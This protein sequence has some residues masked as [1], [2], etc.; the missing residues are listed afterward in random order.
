MAKWTEALFENSY[1]VTVVADLDG[2]VSFITPSVTRVLGYSP[3][4]LLGRSGFDFLHL[5]DLPEALATQAESLDDARA[6]PTL[7]VRARHKDGSVRWLELVLTNRFDDPDIRGLVANI[8][9]IT[10]R[11]VMEERLAA[12]NEELAGT[13]RELAEAV[14]LKDRLMAT[15][16]HEMRAP[17]TLVIG[18]A[19]TMR[20]AWAQLSDED[21]FSFLAK[22]E[23]RGQQL[24]AIVDDLLV[25]GRVERD[26]GGGVCEVA[27]AIREAI[28]ATTVDGTVT[29]SCAPGLVAHADPVHVGQILINYLTNAARYGAPPLAVEACAEG[30]WI[31]IRVRDA[32]PGVPAEFVGDLFEPFT[33]STRARAVTTEGSGLGLA[34]VQQLAR[35]EGG[36]AWYEQNRPHGSC[37][38]V[39]LPA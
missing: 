8:R 38:A 21:K 34:I 3:D 13:N 28:E 5:D 39:R 29:V 18:L 25:L 27:T 6:N 10:R 35:A 19:Q 11:K 23:Q 31:D 16:S 33:R 22:I 36:E 37:F 30:E 4:E 20:S 24:A 14:A 12:L 2:R 1:D 7:E 15:V 9:D 26:G 17:L 32:G